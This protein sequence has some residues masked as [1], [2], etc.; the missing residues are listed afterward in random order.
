LTENEE[1]SGLICRVD[2]ERD[3]SDPGDARC[4]WQQQLSL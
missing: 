2:L 4:A 1:I 3:P